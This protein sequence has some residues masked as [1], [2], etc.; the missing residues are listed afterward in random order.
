MPFHAEDGTPGP[1]GDHTYL[2]GGLRSGLQRAKHRP[3]LPYA[4][5]AGSLAALPE[6]LLLPQLPLQLLLCLRPWPPTLASLSPV[7]HAVPSA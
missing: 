4:P 1:D 3:Q 2:S 6:S 5:G 7:S